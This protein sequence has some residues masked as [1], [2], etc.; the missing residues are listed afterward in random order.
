MPAASVVSQRSALAP[1]NPHDER[2]PRTP[3]NMTMYKA[4]SS[5]EYDL[6][7]SK[8]RAFWYRY[9]GWFHND[10]RKVSRVTEFLSSK[11]NMAWMEYRENN[12]D[13][14]FTWAVFEAW[15]LAQVIDPV[16]MQREAELEWWMTIQAKHQDVHQY[17][18]K[19]TSIYHRLKKAPDRE[20]RI[21]RLR[22][23]VLKEVRDEARRFLGPTTDKSD[24]VGHWG[25][26]CF[27]NLIVECGPIIS[28]LTNM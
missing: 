17:A 18:M 8:Q 16:E 20:H 11:V 19:L 28:T 14:E 2:E 1:P 10:E 26:H 13:M 7:K 9:P 24:D 27:F 5:G 6:F 4:E 22:T 3:S 23:G 15:A 21:Q 25:W 12:P